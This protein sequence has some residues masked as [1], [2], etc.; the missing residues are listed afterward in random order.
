MGAN[1]SSKDGKYTDEPIEIKEKYKMFSLKQGLPSNDN[2]Q[3]TKGYSANLDTS[4]RCSESIM[5][6]IA[7]L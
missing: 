6:L 5:Y 7:I 1:E 4:Q 3:V 2:K